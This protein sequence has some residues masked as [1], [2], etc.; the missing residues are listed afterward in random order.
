MSKKEGLSEDKHTITERRVKTADGLHELYVQEWGNPKGVPIL[1]L[2]GGPG[3]G[4]DDGHKRYFDSQKHR[5][6]FLDQRGSGNSKPY[7]SLKNNETRYLVKDIEL[8]RSKLDIDS[9]HVEGASWGST[10]ALCYAI[11]HSDKI[12]SLIILGVFLGTKEETD[13]LGNGLYKKFYPEV[14]ED[15][16]PRNFNYKLKADQLAYLK[17]F[18]PLLG[19]DDRPKQLPP[20]DELE[21]TPVKTQLYYLN[22]K[23]FLPDNYILQNTNRIKTPVTIIQGRYDMITPPESA[24]KLSKRLEDCKLH[25]TLTGHLPSDR[26]SSSVLTAVLHQLK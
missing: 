12:R 24:H 17:M 1:F 14:Y 6:V 19:V 18:L 25:T 5:V 3:G 7:G 21:L 2:H 20:E 8:V 11:E 13:W 10:L 22:N 15:I 9:W 16:K 4:C 23:Y 26:E